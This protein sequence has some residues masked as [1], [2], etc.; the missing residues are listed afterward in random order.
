MKFRDYYEVLGVAKDASQDE[1][2][3][4]FRKLARKYH[5]DVAAEKS[6]AEEKFKEINEAYEVLSDPEK[7]KKYDTLGAN[8]NQPGGGAAYPDGGF[9]RQ[10][11]TAGGA[12]QEW[13]FEGTGFS[14][15]FE[16]F[17]GGGAKGGFP[18]QA[19]GRPADHRPRRGGDAESEILV[20]LYEAMHG[21]ERVL[22]VQSP[23][24]G[25]QEITIRI[26]K[27]VT[28]GKLIRAPGLGNPGIHGGEPGDLFLHVR[29]ERHPDY[30][31]AGHDLYYDLR[32]SPWE[33]VLGAT[34]PVRTPHGEMKIKVPPGTE[35]GTEFRLGG[36]GL[37]IGKSGNHGNLF[38]VIDVVS[39]PSATA[40]E[41]KH[42]EALAAASNFN[43]R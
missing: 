29:L 19:T 12:G 10:Y 39:P 23:D 15:F 25:R 22:V 31:V 43:P 42:W 11:Q 40:E 28:D 41:Q 9:G 34:V 27:G 21:A 38:A 32:I 8:W 5:P 17:F 37:P 4:A 13:H 18:G 36:K 14:D 35:R 20:T 24:G 3:K 33:A 7:R 2:R 6:T 30:R 1:I 16:N 26:P